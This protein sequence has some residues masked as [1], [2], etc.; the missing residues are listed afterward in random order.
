[1]SDDIVFPCLELFAYLESYLVIIYCLSHLAKKRFQHP[2]HL[3]G[4]PYYIHVLSI[5]SVCYYQT[6][7]EISISKNQENVT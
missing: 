4:E 5:S 6:A 2:I 7:L 1:M 3:H